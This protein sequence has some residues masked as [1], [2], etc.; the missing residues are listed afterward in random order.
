MWFVQFTLFWGKKQTQVTY[1]QKKKKWIWD[2]FSC[3]LTVA[4]TYITHAYC[5]R[6]VSM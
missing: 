4:V 3:S 5:L 1:E 2:T 6:P